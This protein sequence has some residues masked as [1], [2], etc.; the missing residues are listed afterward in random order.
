M[1][2]S[3]GQKLGFLEVVSLNNESK[4]GKSWLCRCVCGKE[5]VIAQSLLIGGKGTKPRKSCGC[6]KHKHGGK[7]AEN[8]RVNKIWHHMIARCYDPL[9]ISFNRYGDKGVTVVDSWRKSF[10]EFCDWALSNGY[11]DDLTLDRIDST[12]GYSPENCRWVDYYHQAQNRGM[13]SDNKT[14]VSGSALRPNGRYMAYINRDN[15][16][17]NLGMYDTLDEVTSAREKAKD[18]YKEHGTLEGYKPVWK[19][20]RKPKSY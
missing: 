14:G 6:R 5:I 13:H 11:S 1:N 8:L 10:I 9:D 15:K 18:Y 19:R 7:V 17:Y 20:L 3:I 12:K 4:R 2:I 16:R